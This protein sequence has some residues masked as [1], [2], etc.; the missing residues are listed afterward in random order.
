MTNEQRF[1]VQILSDH[2]NGRKSE[3]RH[4][5]DWDALLCYANNHQVSGMLFQ[6]CAA[7]LPESVA[8]ILRKRHASELF[9]YFNREKLFKQIADALSAAEIP[10]FSVKG[11]EVARFYPVPA[12]RTMGDCDIVVHAPDRERAHECLMAL[13]FENKQRNDLEWMYLKNNMLVELHA[14]MLYDEAAN[15]QADQA[16]ADSAWSHAHPTGE[17]S[18]YELDWSFHFF[19]LLMHLKKHLIHSGVGFRQFMDLVV[20]MRCCELDWPWIEQ[21]LRQLDL[22]PYARI[23]FALLERWFGVS[24]PLKGANLTEVFYD[25]ATE[26]VFANGIFGFS[27]EEN[28]D[29]AQMRRLASSERPRWLTRGAYLAGV[30]FPRYRDMRYVPQYKFLDGRPWLLPAAWLY[31]YIF[32]LRNKKSTGDHAIAATFIPDEKLAARQQELTKWGL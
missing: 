25:E 9:Y 30:M 20:V 17:G 31:R 26:K 16:A 15:S 14:H 6:Q 23:V 24:A 29:A 19:F 12:L 18:R 3:A 27:D 1:F 32:V 4:D 7:F 11:L 28:Q 8:P 5:L 21:Q 10:F 2:L 22:L 13:G